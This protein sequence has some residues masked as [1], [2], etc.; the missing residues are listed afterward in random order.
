MNHEGAFHLPPRPRILDQTR[1]RLVHNG[2]DRGRSIK[3][4]EAKSTV[5]IQGNAKNF[6]PRGYAVVFEEFTDF[7][8]L[9]LVGDVADEEGSLRRTLRCKGLGLRGG[10]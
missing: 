7:G 8:F 6:V 9:C 5:G 1:Y 10:G 4:H 2:I 3:V